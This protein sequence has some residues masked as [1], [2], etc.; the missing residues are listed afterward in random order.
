MKR[1]RIAGLTFLKGA[2]TFAFAADGVERNLKDF[3]LD[4][5]LVYYKRG[6]WNKYGLMNVNDAI[7]NVNRSGYGADITIEYDE[8]WVNGYAD[9][10]CNVYLSCPCDS[11]MW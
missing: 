9:G 2:E 7:D 8:Q 11:D 10:K 3:I 1:E 5:P 6:V 4:F